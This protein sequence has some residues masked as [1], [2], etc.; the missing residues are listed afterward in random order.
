[1][2][3]KTTYG[4]YSS[5]LTSCSWPLNRKW[6]PIFLMHSIET[7]VF[8]HSTCVFNHW[9]RVF[10]LVDRH[11]FTSMRLSSNSSG[12]HCKY[13]TSSDSSLRVHMVCLVHYL[14][15]SNSPVNVRIGKLICKGRGLILLV[16]GPTVI[17][18][19]S[20]NYTEFYFCYYLSFRMKLVSHFCKLQKKAH[21]ILQ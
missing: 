18:Y 7:H 9:T 6:V 12:M 13:V 8:N 14:S 2:Y 19:L 5:F 4:S 16:T 15:S 10:K 17:N 20:A 11:R 1:M 21:L 3:Y